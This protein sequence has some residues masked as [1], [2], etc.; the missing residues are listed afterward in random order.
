MLLENYCNAPGANM[1][2]IGAGGYD[3]IA[4]AMRAEREKYNE[5][6]VHY[7]QHL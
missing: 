1:V 2:A 7:I 3:R 4:D 5:N 6:T